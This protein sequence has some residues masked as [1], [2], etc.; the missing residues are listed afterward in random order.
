MKSISIIASLF[1]VLLLAST[2]G[3]ID[4]NTNNESTYSTATPYVDD[5]NGITD[6]SGVAIG[7]M[8]TV[9]HHFS[10]YDNQSAAYAIVGDTIIVELEENIANG[11]SWEMTYSEGLKLKEDAYL[12]A[13]IGAELAGA[14]GYH[15]WIFEVTETGE[16]VI[17]GIY[18]RPLEEITGTE[19]GYELTIDVIPESELI[20]TTGT[21]TYKDLEGGFY[22]IVGTDDTRYDLM[23]LPDDFSIDGTEVRFTAYPRDDMMSFHMWGSII[24]I[25]TI[26]PVL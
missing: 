11:Y 15:M 5:Q 3:C 22:G 18:V 6:K 9:Y 26:S 17:S 8:S 12:G 10:E 25:R 4:T 24:E 16:Q 19:D 2:T 7:T 13:S 21:V 1:L 14:P 20:N 23:N